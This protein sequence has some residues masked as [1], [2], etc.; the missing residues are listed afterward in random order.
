MILKALRESN[1]IR[2]KD[3][4]RIK[5]NTNIQKKRNSKLTPNQTK[6][7]FNILILAKAK[8]KKLKSTKYSILL[9]T[10]KLIQ[11]IAN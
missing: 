4:K 3:I 9:R 10:K 11:T 8:R 2:L 5:Y 1:T 6:A 7:S